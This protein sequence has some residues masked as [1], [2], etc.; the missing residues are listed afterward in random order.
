MTPM[1]SRGAKVGEAVLKALGGR[2]DDTWAEQ[3][4]VE[5]LGV[6]GRAPSRAWG[7]D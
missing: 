1:S 6:E 5:V 3:V 4:N 2:R 7:L